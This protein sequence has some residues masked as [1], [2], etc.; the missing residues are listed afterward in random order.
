MTGFGG[1]ISVTEMLEVDEAIR[2]AVME[3]MPTALQEV[4]VKR[5]MRTL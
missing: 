2:E 1:R 3:K 5:G 4:A